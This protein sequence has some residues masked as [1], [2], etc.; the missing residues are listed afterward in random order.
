MLA[1]LPPRHRH[2]PRQPY[3]K[4]RAPTAATQ[5]TTL[6]ACSASS[7]QPPCAEI[8]EDKIKKQESCHLSAILTDV[9]ILAS[10]TFD[11]PPNSTAS[12]PMVTTSPDASPIATAATFFADLVPRLLSDPQSRTTLSSRVLTEE[13]SH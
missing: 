1:R 8:L 13:S 11:N 10:P 5:H 4:F 7:S 6:M 12:S 9:F 2:S 3:A